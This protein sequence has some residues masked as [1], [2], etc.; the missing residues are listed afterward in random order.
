[1]GA[2]LVTAGAVGLYPSIPYEAGLNALRKALDN[3]GDKHISKDNLLKN[4]KWRSLFQKTITLNLM[5][6]LKN[7]C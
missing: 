2:S 5:V 4:G 7:S 6:K 3:R 1:M